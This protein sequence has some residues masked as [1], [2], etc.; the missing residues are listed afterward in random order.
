MSSGWVVGDCGIETKRC[1]DCKAFPLV[2]LFFF[3]FF[4]LGFNLDFEF[5]FNSLGLIVSTFNLLRF[6]FR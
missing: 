5:S 2:L 4:F 1:L 3:G 6:F